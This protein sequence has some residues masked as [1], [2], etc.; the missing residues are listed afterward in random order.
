MGDLCR[1][2]LD[3]GDECW[4]VGTKPND[5][6]MA[7][8]YGQCGVPPSRC[9]WMTEHDEGGAVEDW[10]L[11]CAR[12]T[13]AD[14]IDHQW[15]GAGIPKTWEGI[16]AVCT[17]HGYVGLPGGGFYDAVISVEDLGDG[18][19]AFKMAPR[20]ETIWNW[21]NLERFPFREELPPDGAAFIGRAFKTV[22]AKKVAWLRPDLEIDCFGTAPAGLGPEW[23]PNMKWLGYEKPEN[24]LWNYRVVFASAIAAMEAVAAG[25]L[26][27]VG[28][29]YA[30]RTPWGTLVRP[31]ILP[32]LSRDQF[33]SVMF[34][35]DEPEATAEEVLAQFEAAMANDFTAMRRE[36]RAYI[37]REHAK[38]GQCRKIRDLY[39][40]VLA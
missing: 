20:V 19:Q 12:E 40:E 36:C 7:M 38:E 2:L 34:P 28:Q 37:E 39:E 21:V 1:W 4:I 5:L 29:N 26:V 30:H 10:I 27:V 23:P 25:R 18:H 22:N 14:L 24:I 3:N 15:W 13:G 35:H 16:K 17:L 31:E 33:A 6:G 11:A 32:L 9:L 8:L